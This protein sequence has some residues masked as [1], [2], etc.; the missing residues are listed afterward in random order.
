[1]ATLTIITQNLNAYYW[2][3]GGAKKDPLYEKFIS[4][5]EKDTN[6]KSPLYN[7]LEIIKTRYQEA[8]KAN[9][10]A[11]QEVGELINGRWSGITKTIIENEDR[12]SSNFAKEIWDETFPWTPF[13]SGFWNECDIEFA[14]KQIKIIN[15]HSSPKYDL[16]IRYI[17]LQRLSKIQ[18]KNRLTILLG[19][20]NAAFENQTDTIVID[21][22]KFLTGIK[23]FGFIECIDSKEF[24]GEP[25]YTYSGR[26]KLDHIFISKSLF[27]LLQEYNKN[28]PYAIKYIDKVNRI[29][30]TQSSKTPTG[31]VGRED[32]DKQIEIE[33]FTDHSGIMLTITLPDP[34]PDYE[35]T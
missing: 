2:T 15:F 35:Q 34:E 12:S 7:F 14:K 23:D 20:F 28:E 17:L 31:R 5:I 33:P 32:F 3:H 16:A 8:Y 22:V 19:D 26:K 9:I 25:H 21:N 6:E 27:N 1:M 10:Y 13:V 18:E 30:P 4:E 29:P 11:F 24:G